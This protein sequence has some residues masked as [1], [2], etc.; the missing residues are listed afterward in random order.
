MAKY[1]D[2]LGNEYNSQKEM[3]EHY[4]INPKTF[5]SRIRYKWD[6]KDTLTKDAQESKPKDYLCKDRI[7]E[8]KKANNGMLMTIIVYRTSVD[9]DVQFEDGYVSHNKAYGSFKNGCIGHPKV[10]SVLINNKKR[11]GEKKIANNG[12]EMEIVEYHGTNDITI[13]FSDGTKTSNKS[14]D[15][16][17][18]GEIGNPNIKTKR[19]RNQNRIGERNKNTLGYWMTIIK[20]DSCNDIDVQFDDGSISKNKSYKRFKNGKIGHPKRTESDL[21]KEKYTGLEKIA[22]C[23]LKMKIIKYRRANDIDVQFEDGTIVKHKSCFN[24]VKG[25]ICHDDMD[26]IGEE[27]KNKQGEKMKIIEYINYSDIIVEFGD[28]ST[29]NCRYN[30]FKSGTVSHPNLQ[31]AKK[32]NNKERMNSIGQVMT[33]IQKLEDRKVL[34]EFEDGCRQKVGYREYISGNVKNPNIDTGYKRIKIAF[35]LNNGSVWLYCKC[36]KCGKEYIGT[37]RDVLAHECLK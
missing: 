34:I 15:A 11:I 31:S 28:G 4:D 12:M 19:K 24:F 32:I 14:Y 33:L 35:K 8:T 2:Y 9:I 26:H 10:N 6:L 37:W 36:R 13:V 25:R 16:F 21:S 27:S 23:G 20:Y 17:C 29:R 1:K 22:T 7:G 3:C 5:R 30:H 18:A